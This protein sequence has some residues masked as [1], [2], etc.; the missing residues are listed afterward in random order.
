M[1]DS[2]EYA[3]ALKRLCSR[4]KRSGGKINE[5]AVN[6]PITELVLAGLSV[7]TTESKSRSA[8]GR[9][10][11]SFVDFNELRVARFDEIADVLGKG[12]PQAKDAATR[13]KA[14]LQSVCE[15]NDILSVS[16]LQE[17]GKR[18]AKMFFESLEG[19][20]P[21]IVAR[22]MLLSLQAHAF[23]VNEQMLLMLRDEGA[24]A[25]KADVTD[26]QGFLERQI[27]ANDI[28]ETYRLLRAHAD[29]FK[30][31]RAAT[32]DTATGKKSATAAGTKAKKTRKK[33]SR[34]SSRKKTASKRT[35][36][37]K[38]KTDASGKD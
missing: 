24:V 17:G 27:S 29:A 20:T 15:K 32:K 5:P 4:L 37:K 28:R 10:R 22:V 8:L 38:V 26:V 31:S 19:A 25:P 11:S 18:E 23:P 12:F 36:K 1:K 21:Y 35:V 13:I 14:V 9:L 2:N 6:D 7:A 33:T 34:A 16:H 30:P 3:G